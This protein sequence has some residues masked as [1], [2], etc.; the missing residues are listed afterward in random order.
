LLGSQLE[1]APIRNRDL[2]RP[3]RSADEGRR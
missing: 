3:G 2:S 1:A